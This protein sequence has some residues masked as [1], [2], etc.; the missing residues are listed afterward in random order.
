M[1]HI[2][3]IKMQNKDKRFFDEIEKKH[4]KK[5]IYCLR[6]PRANQIFYIGQGENDRLFSHFNYADICYNTHRK[7]EKLTQKIINIWND[8]KDVEWYIV[9]HNIN[10]CADEI[11]SS[12]ISTLKLQN[13][14][15][16]LNDTIGNNSSFL[17]KEDLV[18]IAAP[19]INPDKEINNVFLFP[20]HNALNE[21][22]DIYESTRRSW[23]I[24]NKFRNLKPSYAVGLVN[25]ISIGA[26]KINGWN[27]FDK[28]TNKYEFYGENYNYFLNYNWRNITSH[29][30][31]WNRGNHLVVNFNG[32]GE[33]K[34]LRGYGDLEQWLDCINE[35]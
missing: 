3:Y 9:A 25:G 4:L 21:V 20:I 12:L 22:N 6:D 10:H 33:F 16:L 19:P 11:E 2:E 26:Y 17:T 5:Y 8:N 14:C 18:K 24:T 34:F 28:A 35:Q 7:A 30:Q 27:L 29:T 15:H 32:K 13:N 31:Y 1:R 23:R